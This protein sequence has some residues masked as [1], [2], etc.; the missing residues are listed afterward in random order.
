MKD[1]SLQITNGKNVTK[2]K[3]ISICKFYF[4]GNLVGESPLPDYSTSDI[5]RAIAEHM[6]IMQYD[7]ATIIDF[8]LGA[9]ASVGKTVN[10]LESDIP[11]VRAEAE[12]IISNR[13]EPGNPGMVTPTDQIRAN[14]KPK[15]SPDETTGAPNIN[16]PISKDKI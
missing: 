10:F 16:R 3:T 9:Q 1:I 7:S 6:G 2:M 4:N 13:V 5:R 14:Y 12:P 8:D 11:S 15:D